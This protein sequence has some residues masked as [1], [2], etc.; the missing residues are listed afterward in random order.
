VWPRFVVVFG[1]AALLAGCGSSG[2]RTGTFLRIDAATG[3]ATT[4]LRPSE[5]TL[6]CDHRA[7]GTGFLRNNARLACTLVREGALQQ[8][9]ADQGNRRNCSQVYG[10]PQHA[11]ITG[12]VEGKRVDLTV[13]RTDGCGTADWQTLEPLLGDPQRRGPVTPAT[14]SPPTTTGAPIRYEVERGDTLTTIAQRFGVSV[15][16]IMFVNNLTDPDQLVEGQ[17]L[18]IP[19]VP[20]VQLV[21][22]PPKAEA[23][24][25]FQFEL[26][27]AK[28]SESIT[29]EI[30]STDGTHIGAPHTA[31]AEG[32]VTA[33]Y[34]TLVED[35]V[36]SYNVLARGSQGTTTEASFRVEPADPGQSES[37]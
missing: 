32:V 11:R 3:S 18:V 14:T 13:T 36:G 15:A 23:G 20:P 30:S 10:G 35:A 4:V 17:S 27:G 6:D 29:F 8:V 12:T 2:T 7:L 22:T 5:A 24:S 25:E 28:P 26:T 34:R 16:A 19:P 9:A 1:V 21:I 31:S 33:T 37:R